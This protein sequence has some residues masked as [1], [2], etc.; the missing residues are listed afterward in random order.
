MKKTD[1]ILIR[2]CPIVKFEWVF[3]NT[4]APAN[5]DHK[6]DV[7]QLSLRLATAHKPDIHHQYNIQ[8]LSESPVEAVKRT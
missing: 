4:E 3:G 7:D 5:S 1:H 2:N 8:H 6:L